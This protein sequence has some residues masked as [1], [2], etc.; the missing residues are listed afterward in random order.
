MRGIEKTRTFGFMT[1]TLAA[2]V[3]AAAKA[4]E[5]DRETLAMLHDASERADQWNRD[6]RALT[7]QDAAVLA[8]RLTSKLARLAPT[9]GVA[10]ALLMQGVALER[11]LS[12][13]YKG[14]T[15]AANTGYHALPR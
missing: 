5:I 1:M 13:D 7:R 6:T 14:A 15:S 4:S 12:G 11:Y 3:G 10:K 8:S 9:E 2:I